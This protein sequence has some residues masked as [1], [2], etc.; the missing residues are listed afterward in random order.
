MLT[1]RSLIAGLAA[2][3]SP[4]F[5]APRRYELDVEKSRVGFT[6]I[7]SNAL[8]QGQM[9]ISRAD[10][11]ID[12]FNLGDSTADVIVN[13]DGARTG[14]FFATE[15][16]KSASVLN[17]A[18]FPEI[19][20]VSRAVRLAPT[21]RLSDGAALVGDLT[22]RGVTRPI[23]LKAQL[24]R[25]PGSA[26]DDLSALTITLKGQISRSAF[27]ATGFAYIVADTVGLD[28]TAAIRAI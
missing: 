7:L 10:L 18:Q 15:A 2:L 5:A 3:A 11:R 6:Y 1:R 22:V 16:L 9:P 13:P 24:F 20:F 14:F 26:P 28:I 19:H 21:G 4:A 25:P 12:P 23:T 8:Q 27:G 17:T